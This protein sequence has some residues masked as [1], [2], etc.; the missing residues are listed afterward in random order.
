MI[1]KDHFKRNIHDRKNKTKIDSNHFKLE[2][3]VVTY[4]VR[5]ERPS[6]SFRH[7]T[8]ILVDAPTDRT[9]PGIKFISMTNT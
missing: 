2:Y 3:H 9:V 1:I 7:E 8:S 6:R 5:T 4:R